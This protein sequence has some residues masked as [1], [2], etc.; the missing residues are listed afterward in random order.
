MTAVGRLIFS[1]WPLKLTALGLAVVL[2]MG[3]AISESTRSWTGPVPIEVL[4]APAGGALLNAPGTVERIEY[5]A[6]DDVAETLTNDSFRASIDLS[7]VQPRPGA[8]SVEVPVDV[9]PV[10]PRVRVIAYE[11]PGVLV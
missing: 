3:L 11:P 9:F 1:N 2:Y 10:D 7:A 5:R 4:N 8:V 6:P